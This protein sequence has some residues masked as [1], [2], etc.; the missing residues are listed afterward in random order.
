MRKQKLKITKQIE[1][2]RENKIWKWLLKKI[3]VTK[4]KL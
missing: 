3:K 2:K 4:Q 1:K